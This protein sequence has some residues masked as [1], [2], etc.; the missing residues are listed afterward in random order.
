MA[1]PLSECMIKMSTARHP[2]QGHHLLNAAGRR[3]VAEA[4][5]AL[6]HQADPDLQQVYAARK[7]VICWH[8]H[9]R[10]ICVFARVCV[11]ACLCVCVFMYVFIYEL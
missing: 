10:S 6:Q 2:V 11:Y 8:T 7:H 5:R 9:I 1:S 3:D 4:E